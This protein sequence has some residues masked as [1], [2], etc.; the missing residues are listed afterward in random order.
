MSRTCTVCTH[1]ARAAIDQAL[2]AGRSAY[3]LASLYRVSHDAITRH[4]ASHL[5]AHVAKAHE[6]EEARQ[7]ID[8]VKQLKVI[9]QVSV[10]ILHEARQAGDSG[11]ALKAIDRLQRKIE[12]QAKLLGELDERPT[13]NVLLA[14]EWLSV[15]TTLLA[16]LG[17]YPEARTAVAQQLLTL[18]G[19]TSN[20]HH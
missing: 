13:V 6:D 18:E 15:R 1:P 5:P 7:A 4:N 17:P 10:A 19:P 2:V 11:T 8:V 3:D 20:G 16:A 9:N 14:P 12:L